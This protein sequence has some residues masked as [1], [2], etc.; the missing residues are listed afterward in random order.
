M[1]YF[2]LLAFAA[3]IAGSCF[4]QKSI[5]D[6]NAV[7]RKVTSFHA[8]E[9][10]DGIDLYL[11]QGNAEAVAVSAAKDEVRERII[12]EVDNGV[13]KIY[14]DQ[15]LFNMEWGNR[16]MKAYVSFKTLDKLKA[17]G[18]SDINVEGS[19]NRGKLIMNFSGGSDF[20]GKV[21]SSDL[22]IEAS[23]GSDVYVSGT[24]STF[25]LHASGGS[26]FHGYDLVTDN[27]NLKASGG[28][29]INITVNKEL[30]VEASGGS[31]V[32]YKGNAVIKSMS[33]SD[34]SVKKAG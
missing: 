18:G 21:S 34:S 12:T 20:H 7:T 19:I 24:A 29:D 10:S 3:I 30:N 8:I 23:G 4:A 28:S 2:I 15:K 14:F 33:G 11:T 9:I 1:K 13:L 5:S 31:D 22:Q 17:S 32:H 27:C 16:K 6:P 26:D 25:R